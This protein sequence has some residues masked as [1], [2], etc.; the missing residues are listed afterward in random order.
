M[1]FAGCRGIMLNQDSVPETTC[2]LQSPTWYEYNL[3]TRFTAME[4]NVVADNRG[5]VVKIARLR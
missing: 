3:H 1:L 4:I 2:L 5:N